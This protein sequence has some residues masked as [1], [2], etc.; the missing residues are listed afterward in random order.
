MDRSVAGRRDFLRYAALGGM[1][2]LGARTAWAQGQG[3]TPALPGGGE[4]GTLYNPGVVQ[5]R[6]P[7]VKADNDDFIMGVEKTLKCQ[8]GCNLDVYTCRTTDF[9][10]NTRRRSTKR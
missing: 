4:N 3:S 1:A 2:L 8:C 9:T 10:C 6:T 7:T 5:Q